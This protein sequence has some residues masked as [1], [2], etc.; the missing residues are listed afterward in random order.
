MPYSKPVDPA[1]ENEENDTLVQ[2]FDFHSASESQQPGLAMSISPT[3]DEGSRMNYIRLEDRLDGIRVF[4]TDATFTDKWIAT[5]DRGNHDVRFVTKFVPGNDNDIAAVYIDGSLRVC[6]TRRT[7][8]TFSSRHRLL[9]QPHGFEGL[10]LVAGP[11]ELALSNSVLE[12]RDKPEGRVRHGTAAGAA[13][14][15]SAKDQHDAVVL[16]RSRNVESRFCVPRRLAGCPPIE[17]PRHFGVA[18]R[19]RCALQRRAA[20]D[21]VVRPPR[22]AASGFER[23]GARRAEFH[24]S[25]ALTT[26]S[27]FS[28]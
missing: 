24:F 7:I 26:T 25:S 21:V 3:G 19:T 9:R 23:A 12:L 18:L 13:Q 17:L 5:L 1:G 2:S 28:C 20:S 6:G 27:T 10:G 8:S 15:E 16:G 14:L 22:R 4:F 11:E